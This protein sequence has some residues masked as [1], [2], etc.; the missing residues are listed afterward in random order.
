MGIR[1]QIPLLVFLT[2]L[3][4]ATHAQLISIPDPGLNAI[5]RRTLQKFDGPLTAQDLLD[6][7]NLDAN[8][9]MCVGSLNG[10]EAAHNLKTL[11]LAFNGLND[12]TS[13]AGL[14]NLTTLDLSGNQVTN[15]SFLN[16]LTSL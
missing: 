10:L 13:L 14:T 5:V 11:G 3:V 7:T 4:S 6:L 12:F 15:F 2:G 1:F 8:C 16:E 9:W